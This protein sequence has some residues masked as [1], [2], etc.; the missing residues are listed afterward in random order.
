[1]QQISL[2]HK[3]FKQQSYSEVDLDRDHLFYIIILA[4]S[5]IPSK[6]KD[7]DS[8]FYSPSAQPDDLF[9]RTIYWK[10][11]QVLPT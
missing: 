7:Q 1:M 10:A 8:S 2:G 6:V 11:N 5:L 4:L 3:K 9:V